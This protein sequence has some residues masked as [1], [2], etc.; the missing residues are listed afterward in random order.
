[1]DHYGIKSL[2]L[3][4]NFIGDSGA[5]SLAKLLEKQIKK[6]TTNKTFGIQDLKL[7][8][9]KINSHGMIP[10]FNALTPKLLKKE[11]TDQNSHKPHMKYLTRQNLKVFHIHQNF[12]DNL[13]Q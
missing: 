4:H 12:F 3:A 9:N 6:S 7:N 8:G 11:N 5:I 13:A 1:M 10:L 2:N